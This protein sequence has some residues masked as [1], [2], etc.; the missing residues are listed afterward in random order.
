MPVHDGPA[1]PGCGLPNYSGMCPVC[2]GDEQAAWN[3]KLPYPWSY[4]PACGSCISPE[5][6]CN[7]CEDIVEHG[8][9]YF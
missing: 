8:D 7:Q 3:E 6:R 5:G 4:C 2:L 1:C 9:V